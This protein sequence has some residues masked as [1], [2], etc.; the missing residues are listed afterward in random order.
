M[1]Y[2]T[3]I[4][5]AG[6]IVQITHQYLQ[7]RWVFRRYLSAEAP[8]LFLELTQAD[9]DAE[10]EAA[11]EDFSEDF[12]EDSLERLAFHR[13]FCAAIATEGQILFHACAMEV[14]GKAYLFAAP[15]GTGKST[16]A[17][18]W[19]RLFGER[20]RI[21]NGD[22]P[23]LGL[24]N[25]QAMVYGTPYQGKE[26]WGY[27]GQAP[28]GGICFLRRGEENTI[29]PISPSEAF[30][31]AYIQLFRPSSPDLLAEAVQTLIAI[32]HR[33]PLYAL[34]CNV[35]PEAAILSYTT[36]TGESL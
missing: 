22:K 24:E 14:E 11:P 16:H 31:L 26:N 28:I 36:L 27:P 19:K 12:S 33:V 15:S 17:F 23:A 5:L 25:G 1:Q 9:I 35:S 20:V 2:T 4:Q 13:K 21:L 18:Q 29:R 30:P 6:H 10:R 7:L 8:Q 34:H 32:L 3:T